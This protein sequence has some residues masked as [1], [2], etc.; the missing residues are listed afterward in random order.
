[1][2]FARLSRLCCLLLLMVLF[3]AIGLAQKDSGNIV[4]VVRDSSGGIVPDAKVTV[5]DID[6]GTTFETTTDA[7]GGFSAGP[8]KVGRYTVTVG[9]ADFKTAEAGPVQLDVQG[10]VEVN[11]KLEVG[12][13]SQRI[14]VTVQNPLLETETSSM[15]EVLNK[16]RIETLPLNGR[17]FAQL[18]AARRGS[19]AQRARVTRQWKLRI[20]RG[21]GAVAPE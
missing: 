1:M 18:G 15:G 17:N 2:A 21:R 8:L 6:R 12:Q 7:S 19:G 20:Q 11:V 16:E 10:R 13:V 14:Q 9:K 4:G 3:P 5:T